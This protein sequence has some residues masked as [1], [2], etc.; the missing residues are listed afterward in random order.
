M[1]TGIS[2]HEQC[3]LISPGCL[4]TQPL[5]KW[6]DKNSL[7][8]SS[9]VPK[10]LQ[11]TFSFDS[12]TEIC[13]GHKTTN[14]TGRKDHISCPK[15]QCVLHNHTLQGVPFTWKVPSIVST[16]KRMEPCRTLTLTTQLL[17]TLIRSESSCHSFPVP[18]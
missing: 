7:D 12:R 5:T 15:V 1:S 14:G 13:D 4:E 18:Q 6:G 9:E 3:H 17:N 2:V 8:Q 16:T 11:T 10:A